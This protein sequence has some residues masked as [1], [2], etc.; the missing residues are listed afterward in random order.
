MYATEVE[1]KNISR[2]AAEI[3]GE[4]ID[5]HVYRPPAC[6][7]S[8]GPL[9]FVFAGYQR[10]A[11]DYLRRAR[12][13]ARRHCMTVIAPELD[14]DSFPRSRYQRGGVSKHDPNPGDTCVGHFLRGLLEWTRELE[15]RH[16]APYVLFGHSAGA[17]MLSRVTAFCP[18]PLPERIV[19]ANPSSYVAPSLSERVPFGF[20]SNS[21][22][23]EQEADLRT[24]LAQPI[25]IYLG[26]AD[27]GNEHLDE[28]ARARR[29]GD[30][31]L[32][33]GKNIYRQARELARKR[34]WKFNWRLV[35]AQ[36][37]GHSSK[38]MLQAAEMEQALGH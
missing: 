8:P 19:I 1:A 6:E 25:T 35:L 10:N 9:L 17:Q 4:I 20:A 27:T 2:H 22:S 32:E 15:G 31:R 29:Q 30:N 24:Y 21:N 11:E 18:P 36:G 33:R 26:T 37:V 7:T 28:S 14:R 16:D 5:V 38:D 13:I 23:D 12:P 34:R 3:D